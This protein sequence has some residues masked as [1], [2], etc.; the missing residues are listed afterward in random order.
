MPQQ[1]Q[2]QQNLVVI[3]PR[4]R[5]NLQVCETVNS[6]AF[7]Q[8]TVVYEG[9]SLQLTP[10]KRND[11]V[12]DVSRRDR[13]FESSAREKHGI[14][15]R[16]LQGQKYRVGEQTVPLNMFDRTKVQRRPRPNQ[17]QSFDRT[18][19]QPRSEHLA[20]RSFEMVPTSGL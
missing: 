17:N 7:K 1:V 2:Q 5:G 15:R 11:T 6:I 9:K 18:R 14:L 8:A 10:A 13:S 4:E 3:A 19:S 20:S 12:Q 16:H